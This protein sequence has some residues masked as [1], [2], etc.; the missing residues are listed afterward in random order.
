[1]VLQSGLDLNIS[2]PTDV[3]FSVSNQKTPFEL[4]VLDLLVL[5]KG[6]GK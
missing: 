6:F 4:E 5:L 2:P 3:A 1:M